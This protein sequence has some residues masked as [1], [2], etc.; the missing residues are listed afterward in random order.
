MKQPSRMRHPRSGHVLASLFAIIALMNIPAAVGTLK[1]SDSARAAVRSAIADQ[2]EQVG[3]DNLLRLDLS[4]LWPTTELTVGYGPHLGLARLLDGSAHWDAYFMH[5][6]D[7]GFYLREARYTLGLTQTFSFGTQSF[8]QLFSVPQAV[9]VAAP[10]AAPDTSPSALSAAATAATPVSLLP[11][12]TG[13]LVPL[14]PVKYLGL[15]SR[16]AFT[17]QFSPRWESHTDA[18]YNVSGGRE[19]DRDLL[20]R[21]DTIDLGSA[22]EYAI[23]RRQSVGGVLRGE[24][25]WTDQGDFW[26]AAMAATWADRVSLPTEVS[27][28]AGISYRNTAETGSPTRAYAFAPVASA[29][30]THSVSLRGSRLLFGLVASYDPSVDALSATVQNRI[31]GLASASWATDH[32]SATLALSGSQGIGDNPVAFVGVSLTLDHRFVDWLGLQGG[33][34]LAS[35]DSGLDATDTLQRAFTTGTIW[36]VFLGLG[37]TLDPQRF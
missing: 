31:T 28:S 8:A 25:G 34:Q 9:N 10:G 11:G 4:L 36:T 17:Y 35:Q 33:G 2:D 15:S 21:L 6:V 23:T 37:A 14:R 13:N 7:A 12:G 29:G 30:I 32:D 26:L 5:E 1:V 22:L 27:F 19:E 3:L 16:A 20:P 18:S 24:R